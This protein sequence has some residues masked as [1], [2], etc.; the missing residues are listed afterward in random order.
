MYIQFKTRN[1]KKYLK[2]LQSSIGSIK[3]DKKIV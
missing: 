2:A 1:I 3:K